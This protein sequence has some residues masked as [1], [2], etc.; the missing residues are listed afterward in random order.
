MDAEYRLWRGPHEGP[1]PCFLKAFTAHLALIAGALSP[2]A[3]FH[4]DGYPGPS[5]PQIHAPA[6][7]S[8]GA[9]GLSST[10]S[11]WDAKHCQ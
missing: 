4:R 5:W 1:A 11:I 10:L 3:G 8:P 6:P 9:D 7:R 2:T